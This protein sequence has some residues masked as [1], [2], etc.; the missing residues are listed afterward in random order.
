MGFIGTGKE[1]E[2]FPSLGGF[3]KESVNIFHVRILSSSKIFERKNLARINMCLTCLGHTIPQRLEVVHNTL[4]M[5][6]GPGVI[7][8]GPALHRIETGINIMP[9]RRAHGRG[10]EAAGK[11]HALLRQFVD[12]GCLSLPPIAADIAKSAVISDN[13]NHVGFGRPRRRYQHEYP[14]EK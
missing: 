9:G 14:Q 7:G 2:G 8:P 12:I 3:R 10:L 4:H 6:I 13:K 11:A 1:T 5:R